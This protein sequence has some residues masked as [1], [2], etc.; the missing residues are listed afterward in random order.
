MCPSRSNNSFWVFDAAPGKMVSIPML[1]CHVGTWKP[2]LDVESTGCLFSGF[3]PLPGNAAQAPI[4]L[5]SINFFADFTTSS[6]LVVR[7]KLYMTISVLSLL[8]LHC[9][10][11][12]QIQTPV[13]ICKRMCVQVCKLHSLCF[14]PNHLCN[15]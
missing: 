13:Q 5:D 11:L 12:Q 14:L 9:S 6:G 2:Y 4:L 1:L 10:S 7:Y 3:W 8:L 15:D